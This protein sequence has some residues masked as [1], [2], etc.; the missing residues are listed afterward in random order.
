MARCPFWGP[1]SP[2]PEREKLRKMVKTLKYY[3]NFEKWQKL[4][5]RTHLF[6]FKNFEN[7]E[8]FKK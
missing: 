2:S 6:L 3:E 5:L 4:E 1:K 8:N 7:G